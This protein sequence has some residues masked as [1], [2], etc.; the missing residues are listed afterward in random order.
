[1]TPQQ[2][3]TLLRYLERHTNRY[4]IDARPEDQLAVA[5]AVFALRDALLRSRRAAA[6]GTAA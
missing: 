6:D 1:M 3:E 5:D 2:M 4:G